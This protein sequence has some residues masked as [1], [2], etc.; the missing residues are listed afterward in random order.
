MNPK[1]GFVT[2]LSTPEETSTV[3]ITFFK[4]KEAFRTSFSHKDKE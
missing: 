2:I 3:E 4:N 1:L